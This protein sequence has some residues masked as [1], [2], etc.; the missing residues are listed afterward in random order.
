MGWIANIFK[1]EAPKKPLKGSAEDVVRFYQQLGFFAGED[2]KAVLDQYNSEFTN[3]LN[4]A[5][6]WDD[7]YL[8]T[9]SKRNVWS[10]DPEADVC[11]QNQVY[12]EVLKE[13]SSISEGI[14]SPTDVRESWGSESGPVTLNFRLNG[15]QMTISPKYLDDWIDLEIL[16]Q[17]NEQIEASGKAF[18]LAV[19]GNFCVGMLLTKE[20]KLK[21]REERQFPFAW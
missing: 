2:P 16:E 1:T 11:S 4:P 13:W 19:D 20:Q 9:L 18:A 3:P 14:F 12:I 5:K 6:A 7:V 8:L 21:M 17:I 10:S 15:T